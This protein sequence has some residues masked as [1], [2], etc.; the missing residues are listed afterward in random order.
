MTDSNVQP[1]LT[2]VADTTTAVIR[3]V[4]PLGELAAFFDRSFTTLAAVAAS[5]NVELTGPAFARYHGVPQGTADLEVGFPTAEAV[6]PA[7]SVEVS[8]LP[9]GPAARLVHHGSY[10]ALGSSWERLGRWMSDQ[11]LEPGPSFWEIYVTQPSPTM[12]P[13]DLRT[14][15]VWPL[16]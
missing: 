9:G 13:A 4:V 2:T 8:S 15:L 16:A 7:D 5:Q 10:D 6:S 1:E 3:G 11:D 12:D 14:E